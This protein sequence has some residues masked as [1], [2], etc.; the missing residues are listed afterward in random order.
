MKIR[1]SLLVAILAAVALPV[2]NLAAA[3]TSDSGLIG[4]RYLGTDL[5]WGHFHS[6]RFNDAYGAAADVNLPLNPGLDASLG[7]AY[8]HLTGPG[9]SGLDHLLSASLIAYNHDEYG[10]PF[11]AATIEQPMDRTTLRGV[12]TKDNET[13]WALGAGLESDLGGGNAVT[14]RVDYSDA[15][16]A[17]P[18]NPTWRYQLQ[19]NHWFTGIASGIV[20]VSYNQVKHAPDSLRYT[21]GVRVLF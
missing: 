16:R 8:S 21:L 15:F 7:Y 5:T 1:K 6:A 10:K 18:R 19:F 20:S 4:K 13:L 12:M 9:L 14:Y 17:G 2:C 3:D 11:F